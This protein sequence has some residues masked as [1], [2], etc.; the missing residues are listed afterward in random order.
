[1]ETI[2]HWVTQH[3][4]AGI[5]SLLMLGIVGVPVPDEAL[6]MFGGYLAYQGELQLLPTIAAATFGSICGISLS[7]GLGRTVGFYLVTEY[8]RFIHITQERV[9][10]VRSWFDRVGRWGLLFGFFIPG[11][12]HL[13]AMT[14]GASRL[15]ISVF[16]M[17]AY[18]GGFLWS[19]TFILVG[20]FLG[21]DWARVSEQIHRHL[22][23]VSGIA[24]ILVLL[25]IGFVAYRRR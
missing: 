8:G 23:I 20:Y 22:T 10:H 1:M 25:Y 3:G 11:V 17:F 6:L 9:D 16:A 2:T 18:T 14:A 19:A 24:V 15:H 5:F 7:Y 21:K 4:Y 12:R 13:T